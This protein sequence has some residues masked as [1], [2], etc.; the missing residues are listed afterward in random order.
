MSSGMPKVTKMERRLDT[1]PVASVP[2]WASRRSGR[3]W[4]RKCGPCDENSPRK[5]S[6]G[7]DGWR[8]RHGCLGRRHG[9][10]GCPVVSDVGCDARP[11]DECVGLWLH[12]GCPLVSWV[13]V[14]QA[15]T[16]QRSGDDDTFLVDRDAVN[17]IQAGPAYRSRHV[18]LFVYILILSKLGLP[19]LYQVL[20]KCN[21]SGTSGQF[22]TA[23]FVLYKEVFLPKR[24]TF[25]YQKIIKIM[26]IMIIIETRV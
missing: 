25:L 3:R 8:R 16:P 2:R 23:G 26:M 22:R 14:L 5:G 24:L 11:E 19:S 7:E 9:I 15:V 1:R 10:A 21:Y 17:R 12:H 18:C 4:P 6:G 13:K 20:W